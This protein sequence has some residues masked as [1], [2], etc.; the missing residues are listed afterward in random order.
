MTEKLE[1]VNLVPEKT[2]ELLGGR[3][4]ESYREHRR[5]YCEWIL[6]KGKHQQRREGYA[7][8]TVKMRAYQLD[9]FYRMV[10]DAEDRYTEEVTP[11][12]AD[13]FLHR[14]ADQD[15]SVSYKAS[16]QKALMSLFAWKEWKIDG[17]V[18]WDPEYRFSRSTS[19]Y[20]IFRKRRAP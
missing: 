4:V 18:T 8:E 6:E 11:D 9:R 13:V 12:H 10:W 15:Y 14:L 1:E 16:F 19:P 20:E 2:A 7:L 17:S 5:E 3:Q